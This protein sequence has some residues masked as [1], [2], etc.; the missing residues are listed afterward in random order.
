MKGV[1]CEGNDLG[2]DS[3]ADGDLEACKRSQRAQG[4]R[5]VVW[6]EERECWGSSQCIKTYTNDCK[7]YDLDCLNSGVYNL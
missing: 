6:F 5:Y 3:S 2:R 1:C 7:N 4:N